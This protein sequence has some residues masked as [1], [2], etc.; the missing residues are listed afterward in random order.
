M[1]IPSQYEFL[2][3]VQ[4]MSDPRGITDIK[5]ATVTSLDG[6]KAIIRFDEDSQPS[7]KVYKAFTSYTPTVGDRVMLIRGIII[8]GW[9]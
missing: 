4:G 1:S 8:G 7:Q 3:T 6:G 9:R 5:T 2:A